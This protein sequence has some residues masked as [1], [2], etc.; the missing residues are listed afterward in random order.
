MSTLLFRNFERDPSLTRIQ[1]HASRLLRLQ[2]VFEAALPPQ[3]ADT[4][5]VSNLKDDNTLLISVRGSAI[6]VRLKQNLP[7]LREHFAR[8]GWPITAIKLKIALPEPA[9]LP[10]APRPR[11]LSLAARRQIEDFAASLPTGDP[12]RV[13][14]ERLARNSLVEDTKACLH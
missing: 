10:P 14:F 11:T 7:S 3:F 13:T 8:A 1:E 9:R 5:R 12:L 4:C 6:A 2:R